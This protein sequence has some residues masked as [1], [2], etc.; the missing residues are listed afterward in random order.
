MPEAEEVKSEREETFVLNLT[1]IPP[2]VSTP[3]TQR[4]TPPHIKPDSPPPQSQEQVFWSSW[5]NQQTNNLECLRMQVQYMGRQVHHTRRINHNVSLQNTQITRI[6]NTVELM[7]ADNLKYQ[8]TIVRLME[9]NQRLH[10]S[11]QSTQQSMLR[12]M[13]SHSAATRDLSATLSN[14]SQHLVVQHTEHPSTSSDGTTPLAIPVTSPPKRSSHINMET[15]TGRGR[16]RSR[17]RQGRH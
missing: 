14:L 4:T 13:E 15:N 12:I 7:R 17:G 3:T 10:Q 9:E 5:A 16:S 2:A 8:E 11:Y 1:P 6:A